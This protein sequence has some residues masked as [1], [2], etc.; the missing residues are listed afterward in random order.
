MKHLITS[1]YA[2]LVKVGDQPPEGFEPVEN[3]TLRTT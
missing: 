3:P 1:R 2:I